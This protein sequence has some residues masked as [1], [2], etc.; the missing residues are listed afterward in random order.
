MTKLR[1]VRAL[2]LVM[3]VFMMAVA[4]GSL[5]GAYMMLMQGIGVLRPET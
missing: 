5:A 3:N 1:P 2:F 4:V